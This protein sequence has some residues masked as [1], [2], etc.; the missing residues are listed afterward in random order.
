MILLLTTIFICLHISVHVSMIDHFDHNITAGFI[1]IFI[2]QQKCCVSRSQ[3]INALVIGVFTSVN[4]NNKCVVRDALSESEKD[5]HGSDV[6]EITSFYYPGDSL[7]HRDMSR[8]GFLQHDWDRQRLSLKGIVQSICRLSLFRT[9]ISF[10][11]R[12]VYSYELFV[13][14]TE[15]TAVQQKDGDRTKTQIIKRRI[16][17]N[18]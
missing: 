16:K 9:R 15:A 8:H 14:V 6:H 11:A 18:K 13:F 10:M 4:I 17:K 12:Y 3:S 1:D 7:L 2:D 5:N